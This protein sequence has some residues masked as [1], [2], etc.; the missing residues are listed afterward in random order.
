MNNTICTLVASDASFIMGFHGAL[1]EGSI[2]MITDSSL[3][4]YVSS[5]SSR[6]LELAAT[7]AR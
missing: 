4:T 1:R 3:R 2:A 7:D 6:D 5:G